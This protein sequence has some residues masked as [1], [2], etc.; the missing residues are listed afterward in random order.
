MVVA[1]DDDEGQVVVAQ[2]RGKLERLV[3]VM[4]DTARRHRPADVQ[5]VVQTADSD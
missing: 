3:Q 5:E 1:E 2:M 4:S